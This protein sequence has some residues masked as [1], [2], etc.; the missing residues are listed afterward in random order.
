MKKIFVLV[1][2]VLMLAILLTGC[3]SQP[4]TT[5]P[6]VNAGPTETPT[7]IPVSTVVQGSSSFPTGVNWR[8]FSYTD[9]K[10]GMANVI[11]E[12][13][14]TA[15]FRADG[16]VTGSSGCNQYNA[17]YTASGSSIT[18]T[19]GISTLMACVPVVM[20][21]ESRYFSL[22]ANATTYSVNEDTMVFFD[23]SGK[24][25]L[26]YKRPLDIPVTISA[27]APVVG[28]W[29][30]L[31]YYNGN[32]AMVSVLSGSTISADFMPDGKITGSSG[33]NEYSATY[34]SNG[35][36]LGIIQVKST[37]MA[38]DPGIMTQENQYL[39]LLPKV[40]TYQMSGDQ[41]VLYTVLGQ[42]IL[43]YKKGDVGTI[44]APPKSTPS[45]S[46]R[47][48][49]GAWA[50]KSYTDGKG[51]YVPVLEATP[52]TA[53]FLADGSLSGSSGC[54]QY[55]TTYSVSGESISISQA[56]TTRMACEPVVMS[57][58]TTYLTLLQKAGKFVIFGDSMTLYDSTGAV[59]LNYKAP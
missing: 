22:L 37:K 55:T 35:Q 41:M 31:T 13:P 58:E 33:C 52:V 51:G 28:S 2:A 48:L 50:L 49:V 8:L 15:L 16:T 21:Q 9:G 20:S 57:Q 4:V 34:S 44:T 36:T 43:Q 23:R 27:Q 29:D 12:Q 17:G 11:G 14:V 6:V 7:V 30:L 40:N 53:K 10:G 25:I 54:N 45:T 32:N 3:T 39:A 19:P 5:A 46:P 59:L 42:K 38:C 56:A 1:G 18:I 26:A 47:T 24:V